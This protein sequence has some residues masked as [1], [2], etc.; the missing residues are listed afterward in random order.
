MLDFVADRRPP[1]VVRVHVCARV[2]TLRRAP[3]CVLLRST[4]LW[5]AYRCTDEQFGTAFRGASSS[6]L[7]GTTATV[8]VVDGYHVLVANVGDSRAV[9]SR[10]GNALALTDDHKA[11]RP[12]E[13]ARI[14]NAGASRHPAPES[15]LCLA[16]WLRVGDTH[17][18]THTYHPM[19]ERT[20][21]S[22]CSSV[23]CDHLRRFY[24]PRDVPL[25]SSLHRSVPA[26]CATP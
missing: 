2:L 15:S 20:A 5:N 11:N 8:A 6:E 25:A 22:S 23:S 4:A 14:V 3:S 9:L 13:I 24:C 1:A 26:C 7:S 10:D 16:P 21:F 19:H 12:D 17:A 18:H